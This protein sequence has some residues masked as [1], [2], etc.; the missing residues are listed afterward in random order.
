MET[1][2]GILIALRSI[3]RMAI[4]RSGRS[5]QKHVVC[6][7]SSFL[8]TAFLPHL[9]TN[10]PGAKRFNLPLSFLT[11]FFCHPFPLRRVST[12]YAQIILYRVHPP[13]RSASCPVRASAFQS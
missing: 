7:S 8:L 12:D 13:A 2:E 3:V 9:Q 10:W 11:L 6:D 5:L 4:V 1:M